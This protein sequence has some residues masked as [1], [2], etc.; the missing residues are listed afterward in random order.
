VIDA[1]RALADDPAATAVLADF[2]GSL[3]AIV[4]HP[5]DAVPVDGAVAVLGRLTQR[6]A[7]V[8]IV[9]GRPVE[10][11]RRVVPVDG[12]AL[13]GQYGLETWNPIRSCIEVD[14]AAVPYA[15]AV[16]EV[17]AAA[18][19]ELPGVFVERK[20]TV[21]VTLHWRMQPEVGSATSE[22]AERQA[23]THG[24]TRYPT[25]MAV[26]LRPPVPVDKGRGV[27]RLVAGMRHALFAGDDH[28]D[29]SGFDAL[30]R[31]VAGGSLQHAV[32]IAVR[33]SEEP[34]ELVARADVHVDGPDALVALL[35]DLAG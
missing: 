22:W 1:L 14:D 11:L 7:C 24:L 8:G 23:E 10:F 17:A 18:E 13:V 27:E 3:S 12:L 33:S 35:A 20:G 34:P 4:D 26:E 16:A 30:D 15:G 31:L 5:D 29:L 32:R 2:D 19:T 9:S 28:G 21:A 25:R 6:F